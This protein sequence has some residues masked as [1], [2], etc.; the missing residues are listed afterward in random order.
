M[1]GVPGRRGGRAVART[2]LETWRRKQRRAAF[3][4]C[5]QARQ[6][7]YYLPIV[8]LPHDAQQ[9]VQAQALLLLRRLRLL[10]LLLGARCCLVGR[11][12]LLLPLARSA[13]HAD[14]ER[15]LGSC[16][17]GSCCHGIG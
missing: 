14:I 15:P 1:R 12:P 8:V 7:Q 6:N 4:G 9:R 2:G 13:W 17:G 3:S 10:R 11:L 16:G 5:V